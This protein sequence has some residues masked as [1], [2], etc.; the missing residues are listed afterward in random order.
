MDALGLPPEVISITN[1]KRNFELHLLNCGKSLSEWQDSRAELETALGVVISKI[2]I[3][4]GERNLVLVC[5]PSDMAFKADNAISEESR[6]N[7]LKLSI[8]YKAEGAEVIDLNRTA[9]V[10]IGGATGSGKTVLL[11]T[12][13]AMLIHRGCEVIICDFKGGID[14]PEPIWKESRLAPEPTG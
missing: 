6:P 9:H 7:G 13:L 8:G 14:F 4:R 11:R 2:Q 10:L 5:V 12:I 3:T 1:N